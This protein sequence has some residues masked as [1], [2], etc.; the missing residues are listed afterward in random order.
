MMMSDV[1]LDK[2]ILR[3]E[4]GVHPLGDDAIQ[5]ASIDLRLGYE[6][7]VA[8]RM[9]HAIDPVRGDLPRHCRIDASELDGEFLLHPGAFVLGT[10][11]ETITLGAGLCARVE[12]KSSW[13]R[14]GVI[15]HSTAGFIDPGF[16]GRIT[17]EMTNISGNDIVLRPGHYICQL[18]VQQ[19]STPSARPYGHETRRSKYQGQSTVQEPKWDLKTPR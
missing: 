19:L 2:A 16:T 1:D 12:G 15:V 5:P 4:L 8:A 13:G 18:A 10:T 3:G 6:F 7:L 11:L 9:R 17:L 14:L